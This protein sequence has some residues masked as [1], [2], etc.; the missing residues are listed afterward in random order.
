MSLSDA[1]AGR[2]LL[3]ENDV[4]TAGGLSRM[5][6]AAGYRVRQ[7][8]NGVAGLF[9]ALAQPVDLILLSRDLPVFNGL[10]VCRAL[11]ELAETAAIPVIFLVGPGDSAGPIAD[12]YAGAVDT[13]AKPLVES[14]VLARIATHMGMA[15]AARMLLTQRRRQT[16]GGSAVNENT[17][18]EN[19]AD[20]NPARPTLPE[21]LVVED[22]PECRLLISTLLKGAGYQVR[23]APNGELALWSATHRPPDLVLLDV[24]MPG[25]DGFEVCRRLNANA[26]TAAIPVIFLTALEGAT[27]RAQAFAVGAV[28]FLSKPIVA[29]EVLDRVR[30]HLL[31]AGGSP[32]APDESETAHAGEVAERFVA[33]PDINAFERMFMPCHQAVVVVDEEARVSY[34]NPAFLSQTGLPAEACIDQPL[35]F[36]LGMPD[37]T[38]MPA[39]LA[40]ECWT[41]KIQINPAAQAPWRARACAVPVPLRLTLPMPPPASTGGR[42]VVLVIDS[43][44]L[45]DQP[46]EDVPQ[47]SPRPERLYRLE[48][49]LRNARQ[50]GQLS[51][52]YQPV[53]AWPA[54]RW[55]AAE[56]Q[57][58]WLAP[59]FGCLALRDFLRLAEET[60]EIIAIGEW[61]AAR[62]CTDYSAWP[63]DLADSLTLTIRLT[64]MEFWQASLVSRLRGIL[65]DTAC[66]PP[67]LCLTVEE[68][69]L[70]EDYA[71]ALRLIAR[72]RALGVGLALERSGPERLSVADLQ[73]L[74]L[75]SLVVPQRVAAPTAT[76]AGAGAEVAGWVEAGH[77]RGWSVRVSGINGPGDMDWAR[78]YAFDQAQ[79]K[80][81]ALPMGADEFL[82]R[83]GENHARHPV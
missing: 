40:G 53:L 60:G 1:D 9:S 63:A 8:D 21:I 28:D 58:S 65:S 59:D 67:V 50:H 12:S 62:V 46:A 26:L 61:V 44:P 33:A 31:L 71:Q 56:A 57:V 15:L 34:L 52:Q 32:P 79:G 82:V 20:S 45:D 55:V 37:P 49:L 81:L 66:P 16:E 7:A 68:T 5:L 41:G 73:R 6:A 74:P 2:I 76:H 24:Q 39:L 19:N 17:G 4:E 22:T 18:D 27:D 80:H 25:M 64:A 36:L 69:C 72:L 75:T 78:A 11:K 10:D 38:L 13:I 23:E 83:C 30:A 70:C 47:P 77:Q 54:G 35:A 3:V 51:L 14:D 29:Q 42:R 43:S 48:G